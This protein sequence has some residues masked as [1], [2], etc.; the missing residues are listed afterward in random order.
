MFTIVDLLCESRVNVAVSP[1]ANVERVASLTRL[2]S[3]DS[4]LPAD[5]ALLHTTP[6]RAWVI[7]MMGVYPNQSGLNLSGEA[8]G[9]ADILCPQAGSEAIFARVG[10]K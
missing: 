10:Q 7:A 3:F 1:G 9:L 8:V 5:A 2:E 6:R 4:I